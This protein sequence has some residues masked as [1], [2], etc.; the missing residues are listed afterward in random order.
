MG[1]KT[2]DKT[3]DRVRD[4]VGRSGRAGLFAAC[5]IACGLP[6]LV[7]LGALSASAAAVGGTTAAGLTAVAF[8]A[9]LVVR[10]RAPAIS[11]VMTRRVFAAS[12]SLTAAGLLLSARDGGRSGATLLVVG[13]A[14]LSCLALLRLAAAHERRGPAGLGG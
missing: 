4:R 3:G 9:Y 10:G 13:I 2:G 12:G 6:M 5:A 14:V 11:E 7:A 1:D 8:V